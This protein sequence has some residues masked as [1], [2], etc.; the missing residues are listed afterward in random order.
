MKVC[1]VHAP[2]PIADAFRTLGHTVLEL[3]PEAGKIH[4]IGETL[5]RKGFKPDL[6]LQTELLAKRVIL[7]GLDNIACP[8]LFWCLDPHLNAF[9]HSA[10][11]RLFD[12]T[13]STQKRWMAEIGRR[14]AKDI[15]RLPWFG[16]EAPWTP[17]EKRPYDLAFVG[18]MS[19]QRPARL[20]F[21]DF[22][23]KH[24]SNKANL[25]LE[26]NLKHEQMLTL[27]QQ[28]RL[29][30]NETIFGEVNFR[31]FESASCGCLPLDP[32]LGEEHQGLFEPGKEIETYSD[33]LEFKAVLELRLRNRKQ[34]GIMA[35]AARERILREHLPVHRAAA[36]LDM[37]AQASPEAAS[38]PE[39]DKWFWLTAFHLWEAGRIALK[40]GLI[41]RALGA[42]PPDEE[43]LS[44]LVRMR[45]MTDKEEK[46]ANTMKAILAEDAFAD[47]LELNLACSMAALK[48]NLWEMAKEF[49]YRR[50]KT[51]TGSHPMPPDDPVRL[52]MLWS[53]ELVRAGLLVR[54]GFPFDGEKHLPM[55][56][57]ECLAGVLD[58]EPENLEALRRFE[59]TFRDFR[60]MEQ[61]RVGFLSIL[62]LH[63]RTDWRMGIEIGLAG[64]RS[65]RLEAGLDE[66]LLAGNLAEKQGET[67]NFLRVLKARDP[68]GLAFKALERDI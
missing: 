3:R 1:L 53:G 6:L 33:V 15:R 34:T 47:H 5:D 52:L 10:Y 16:F 21:V 44:A 46:A 26:Q 20:W 24:F 37:A 66:L 36:I 50:L 61:T 11:A 56:A 68:S 58:L 55:S 41:E 59:T 29:A 35:L 64:L 54:A 67:N 65:F 12:L 57:S 45:A 4:D 7:S 62:T 8:K 38:G 22:L 23:K 32:D 39:S 42:L 19:K 25:A 49:W 28:S 14:G 27:Y 9:W 43:V 17:W 13:L 51:V 31:L 2:R 30:P 48:A 40:P 63:E 60:G 18:R